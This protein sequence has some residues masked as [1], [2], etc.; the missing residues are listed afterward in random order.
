MAGTRSFTRYAKR[1]LSRWYYFILALLL[2]LPAAYM[3]L[4]LTP[5]EYAVKAS[6]MVAAPAQKQDPKVVGQNEDGPL[7][8]GIVE[9]EVGILSSNSLI[10]KSLRELDFGVV[11]CLEN[12]FA[13]REEYDNSYF[14]IILDSAVNQAV[15][16]P[17]YVKRISSTR[18]HVKVSARNV[19]LYNCFSNKVES[20]IKELEIDEEVP[21]NKPLGNKYLNFRIAFNDKYKVGAG[22]EM[23]FVLRPLNFLVASY[24]RRYSVQ[25]ISDDS[26]IVSLTVNGE[27][28]EKEKVFLNVIIQQYLQATSDAAHGTSMQ[29]LKF[30]EDQLNN[31]P[32]TLSDKLR[33]YLTEK[34][35][36][37]RMALASAAAN[38]SIV[39]K[40]YTAGEGKPVWPIHDIV[41]ILAIAAAFLIVILA[42]VGNDMWRDTVLSAEDVELTT[43]IPLV[44]T[45]S[46]AKKREQNTIVA[47]A[48]SAVGESFRSLRVNLQYL[49]LD[50]GANV[51]GI[52][53][54]RES[55][56]KTFCAVNLAAVMAYSGRRTVLIDTDMR[57]PRV[58]SYFQLENRKGLSNFLVGDGSIKEIINNTEH[59]GFDVIGSG[60]IPPNPIDLI[61]NPR[62]EELI[63]ALRQSY[64]TVII[65]SPPLGYVSEYIIL[66]KYTDANLYIVR[67]DYTNRKSLKRLNKLV[68]REKVGNFNIVLNDVRP[69]KESGNYYAYG[70]GYGYKY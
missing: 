52:T 8:R 9:D 29:A 17:V 28:P 27:V 55:E 12:Q 60:P 22:D 38:K 15:N 69:S 34:R 7:T 1:I 3:Y 70:Y 61:G 66:M 48:R 47:H 37:M 31:P 16:I 65:D 40:P 42:L 36:E 30:I 24:Q 63:Q 54:S 20:T 23:F 53:S 2:A 67:S 49:T 19:Q 68:A 39:D 51:I 50:A 10:E 33:A 14:K 43:K 41:Y 5:P 59:K 56:G 6:I 35:V 11:Y 21:L 44:A 25:P 32:D 18:Y 58:A 46:H 64:S 57:R 13:V 45:I 4:Y 26:R 62:M